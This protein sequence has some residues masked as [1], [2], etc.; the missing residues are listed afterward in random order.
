[1]IWIAAIISSLLLDLGT[2]TSSNRDRIIDRNAVR[3]QRKRCR[4]ENI[5]EKVNMNSIYFD[6]KIDS[7]L[8]SSR[9]KLDEEQITIINE[10]GN[11][12]IC[13]TVSRNV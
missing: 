2:I 6:E 12:Y 5:P 3:R 1:M 11:E 4:S 13:H 7:T 9:K 8:Q 10:P